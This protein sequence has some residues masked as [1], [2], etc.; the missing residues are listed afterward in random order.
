MK[1]YIFSVVLWDEESAVA[2]E[3]DLEINVTVDSVP[4]VYENVLKKALNRA[5]KK[6]KAKNMKVM[7]IEYK[8]VV[9]SE[10]G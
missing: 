9:Y 7:S 8:G 1:K 2:N 5:I 3:T 4:S 6:S 10:E